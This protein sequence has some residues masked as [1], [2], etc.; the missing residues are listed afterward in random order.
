MKVDVQKAKQ[1]CPQ[2]GALVNV[3]RLQRHMNSRCNARQNN[4]PPGDPTTLSSPYQEPQILP[5]LEA[6]RQEYSDR[7]DA[8]RGWGQAF[9]DNGAFGSY[10]AHDNYSDEASS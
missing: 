7:Y 3:S 10:P 4:K 1:D 8:S 2:C 9:R 5:S 6:F